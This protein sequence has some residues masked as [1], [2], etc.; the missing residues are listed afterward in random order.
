L[1]TL[2]DSE[3]R[4]EI[5][6]NDSWIEKTFG[7]TA[8][9][10]FRPPGGIH[11]ERIDG[12]CG[13]LGYTRILLWQGSFH[14]S[15]PVTSEELWNSAESALHPGAVVLGHANQPTVIAMLGRL[16]SLMDERRLESATLDELFGT[17]RKVG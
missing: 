17:T 14:D 11:D 13:E 9:P 6:R 3:V 1:T 8:R 16:A 4:D 5:E 2:K 12:I 10:Y 7:T 15:V